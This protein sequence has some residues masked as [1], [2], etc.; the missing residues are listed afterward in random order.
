M[1]QVTS[2]IENNNG[3]S[4]TLDFAYDG[5]GNRTPLEDST[6]ATVNSVY[7]ADNE[8]VGETYSQAGTIGLEFEQQYNWR[9]VNGGLGFGTPKP[10]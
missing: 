7:D 1:N 4:T 5:N 2:V 3:T 8:L 6:G 10:R 9:A